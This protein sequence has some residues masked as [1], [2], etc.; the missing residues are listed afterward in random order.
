MH[1]S[2]LDFDLPQH[3]IAQVPVEPR[4]A[5]RLMLLDRQGGGISHARF[6]H[7]GMHLR[8]GDLL[9]LNQTRVLPARLKGTKH[10][11][12][13]AEILLLRKLDS[14]HWR[15]LVGGHR[16]GEVRFEKA[17]VT[18]KV[19][20]AENAGPERT[21]AF[22][23]PVE[24]HLHAIGDVPLPPYIKQRLS[25]PERYQTVYSR[26]AGSAAAPT[27]GLHFTNNLMAQLERAGIQRA[28]VT[29]HVGLDTF[30]PITGER[31]EDHAIHSE[32][33]DLP[34]ETAAAIAKT[35]QQGG[36]VIAVGTTSVRVLESEAAVRGA[37]ERPRQFVGDTRLFIT[38][39]F[40]FKNVDAMITNFHL[41]RSSLLALVGAFVG[42]EVLRDAYRI[43]IEEQYRFFSFGDAMFIA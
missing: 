29:L 6:D 36:R 33:C 43:A 32:W 40:V 30:K 11:G 20:P 18:A 31:V 39:G 21:V 19:L 34:S 35:K 5:S 4:D 22:S 12:G 27:A 2:E 28:F 42:M 14:T 13:K 7:I 17:S 26:L 15:A 16:V 25:D 23:E 8:A 9:V 1:T 38:P 41:P 3:L 24:P 37:T 10:T